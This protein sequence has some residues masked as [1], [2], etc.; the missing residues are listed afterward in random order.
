MT[1][2]IQ[3]IT[4]GR[5]KTALYD[6]IV[7]FEEYAKQRELSKNRKTCH[8]SKPPVVSWWITA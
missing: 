3:K 4:R 2:P 1:G 6:D 5:E 8:R 7:G